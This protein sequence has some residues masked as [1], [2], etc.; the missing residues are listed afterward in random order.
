LHA[1]PE[2]GCEYPVHPHPDTEH[3]VASFLVPLFVDD[4]HFGLQ[5]LFVFVMAISSLDVYKK[6]WRKNRQSA[7]SM[8]AFR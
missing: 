8:S 5:L 3:A 4:A 2:S 1:E 7:K 6:V